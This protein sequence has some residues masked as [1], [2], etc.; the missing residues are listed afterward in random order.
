VQG[1][2]TAGAPV[3]A[4]AAVALRSAW[5]E[6]NRPWGV[7]LRERHP[8]RVLQE[9]QAISQ[10]MHRSVVIVLEEVPDESA[11]EAETQA[12]AT[13]TPPPASAEVPPPPPM[14]VLER[15]VSEL[16]RRTLE[17]FEAH[18]F[19]LA[20]MESQ[21]AMERARR[22]EVAPPPS[23]VAQRRGASAARPVASPAAP[24]RPELQR[25]VSQE[26]RRESQIQRVMDI[27][28]ML[29][30]EALQALQDHDWSEEAAI[31]AHFDAFMAESDSD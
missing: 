31:N 6:A 13:L 27:T 21:E 9:G 4:L 5:G 16:Q 11:L 30:D 24:Q 20:G 10:D 25:T 14:P 29:H 2:F 3:A 22:G 18:A 23:S 15:N 1:C 28:G 19:E 7:R 17:A 12:S 26:E 8:P